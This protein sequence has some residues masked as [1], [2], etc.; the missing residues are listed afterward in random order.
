MTFT[1]KKNELEIEEITIKHTIHKEK[2]IIVGAYWTDKKRGNDFAMI[3]H[4][5]KLTLRLPNDFFECQDN[6]D[7]KELTFTPDELIIQGLLYDVKRNL[8]RGWDPDEYIEEKYNM[9]FEKVET[10][11]NSNNFQSQKEEK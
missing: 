8:E 9:K 3:Y 10:D 5:D 7:H 11:T 2:G 4:N 1:E 6:L